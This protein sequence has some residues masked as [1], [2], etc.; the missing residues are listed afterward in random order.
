MMHTRQPERWRLAGGGQVVAF[1]TD[2]AAFPLQPHGTREADRT[3][4][5]RL[6]SAQLHSV[7][8]AS[9]AAT[10]ASGESHARAGANGIAL[11]PTHQHAVQPQLEPKRSVRLQYEEHIVNAVSRVLHVFWIMVFTVCSDQRD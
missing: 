10:P 5:A 6:T 2:A 1:G 11:K 8:E 4:L 7:K 9:S 3:R